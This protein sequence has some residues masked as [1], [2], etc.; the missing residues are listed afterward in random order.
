MSASR[1]LITV[2]SSISN[3]AP[4]LRAA[5]LPLV[6]IVDEEALS[7]YGG[8]VEFDV[9]KLQESTKA[10]LRAAEILITEPSALADMLSLDEADLFSNLKWCQSTYAGVDPLFKAKL[11]FPLPFTLTRFAGVFGPPI[12]EWCLARIIGHERGFSASRKDQEEHQA[13]AKSTEILEYRYLSDLTLSILGCGDIGLCIGKAAKAFGMTVVGFSTTPRSNEP[14][15]DRS[16]TD[17]KEALQTG[18]YVVSVLPST[19]VTRG[20]LTLDALTAANKENG[21]KSPVFLNVGRG[22][23]TNTETILQALQDNHISAAILDV[24]EVEPLPQTNPL[25]KHP[26][27]TISPHVSGLTRAQDVPKLVVEQYERYCQ[28]EE[29]VYKVDW[30]KSY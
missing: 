9:S 18:D 6:E 1:P 17:L 12:A 8:T 7:G 26:K 22:D 20:L 28:G 15:L 2:F 24:F 4:A 13:W 10:K 27:V 21:G 16:V 29:L 3:I 25:W 23:V 11:E 30:E 14:A 19:K 5:G